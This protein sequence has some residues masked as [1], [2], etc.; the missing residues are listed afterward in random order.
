MEVESFSDSSCTDDEPLSWISWFCEKPE[1]VFYC[2][3]DFDYIE[4]AF[5][6]YGLKEVV[7]DFKRCRRT[8]LEEIN[9]SSSM[10]ENI[11]KYWARPEVADLY[12]RIHAR[13]IVTN[14]GQRAMAQKFREG[15]FGKCR[16]YLCPRQYVLPIGLS[17]VLKQEEVKVYC[18]KCH[19]IYNTERSTVDGAYFGRTFPHFLL[20][21]RPDLLPRIM[22]REVTPRPYVPTVFGFRLHKTSAF[23]AKRTPP[24][25]SSA[26]A[27]RAAAF[28]GGYQK[29]KA[30]NAMPAMTHVSKAFNDQ[31]KK[32]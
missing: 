17:D 18:P 24:N 7:A 20:I 4:S 3:V 30:T 2:Q 11:P 8:I 14:A 12:G 19:E 16:N 13:Y 23:Y 22:T 25:A 31:G 27:P 28:P 6:L 9:D 10:D 29:A 5:N 21:C 15:H 26:A 32:K 1:N